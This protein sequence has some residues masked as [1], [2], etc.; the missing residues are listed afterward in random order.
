L[1]I[2]VPKGNP[3]SIKTLKDLGKAGIRIGVGH[4]KQCALG[5][6]TQTTLGQAG[7]YGEVRK[8]VVAESAT[9]DLLVNQLRTGSLDAVIAYISNAAGSGD[10]L[11]AIAIDLPCAVATQPMAV[12]RASENKGIAGRLMGAIGSAESRRVFEANGFG[13]KAGAR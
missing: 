6:L 5:A 10:K 3:H 7:V 12:S 13:W 4:E 9:G 11:E 8:N 1:V 2:L